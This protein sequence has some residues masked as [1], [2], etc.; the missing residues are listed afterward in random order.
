M[1]NYKNVF[2][3]NECKLLEKLGF[4]GNRIEYRKFDMI[5]EK[6]YSAKME[7]KKIILTKYDLHKKYEMDFTFKTVREVLNFV[8][9]KFRL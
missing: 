8:N 7:N 4:G 1:T 3:D 5:E 2:N 9:N 6:Y